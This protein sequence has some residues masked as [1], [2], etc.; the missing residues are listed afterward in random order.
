MEFFIKQ[1]KQK[2]S[3]YD[4]EMWFLNKVMHFA[5]LTGDKKQYHLTIAKLWNHLNK[6][7]IGFIESQMHLKECENKIHDLEKKLNNK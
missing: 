7:H 1:F 2:T 6:I 5:F 3:C 4:Y